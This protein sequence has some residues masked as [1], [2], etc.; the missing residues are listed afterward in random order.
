MRRD[1][2]RGGKTYRE[3]GKGIGGGAERPRKL[4]FWINVLKSSV[5]YPN[6]LLVAIEELGRIQKFCI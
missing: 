3:K 6:V 4:T 1:R 5:Y 2:K